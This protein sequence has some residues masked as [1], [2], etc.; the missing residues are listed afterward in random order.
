MSEHAVEPSLPTD[1]RGRAGLRL[2]GT[3]AMGSPAGAADALS[4]LHAL[5]SSPATAADALA[6]LHELQVHQVELDLQS[7]ELN[8]A[9]GELEATLHRHSERYDHLPVGCLTL[10]GDLVV[11]ELNLRAARLLGVDRQR[12]VGMP[13]AGFLDAPS[14]QRLRATTARIDAGRESAA[15]PLVL[16]PPNAPG[17]AVTALVGADPAARGYLIGLAPDTDAAQRD[18]A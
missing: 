2:A 18:L 9:R 4:V 13:L 5:A 17:R 12:A 7:H 1:L 8:E 16:G 14:A 6:L 3:A 15:C 11:Q 10:D